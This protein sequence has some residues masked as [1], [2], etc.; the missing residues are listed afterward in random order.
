MIEARYGQ[1][2]PTVP[3][4]VSVPISAA[5]TTRPLCHPAASANGLAPDPPAHGGPNLF[6]LP[7]RLVPQP[8]GLFD[9]LP[10]T[11]NGLCRFIQI[12]SLG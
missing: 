8:L 9:K 2:T 7:V 12:G 5:Y 4:K 3:G 11:R 6:D 10:P 1:P